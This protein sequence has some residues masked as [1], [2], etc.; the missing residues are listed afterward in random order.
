MLTEAEQFFKLVG[1]YTVPK[2]F[3][4]VDRHN[5]DIKLVF[6]QQITTALDIDLLKCERVIASSSTNRFLRVVTKMTTWS[7][8]NNHMSFRQLRL[9]PKGDMRA[10]FGKNSCQLITKQGI[11]VSADH[12]ILIF[13]RPALFMIKLIIRLA[14]QRV[15]PVGGGV[16]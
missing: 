2:R 11:N 14:A 7:R 4:I 16:V 5:G 12:I 1:I 6:Q 13:V 8:V 9:T 10:S 15:I 3:D